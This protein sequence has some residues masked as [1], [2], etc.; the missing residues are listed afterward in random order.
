VKKVPGGRRR[1]AAN[2]LK[3]PG[4]FLQRRGNTRVA[5]GLILLLSIA[6]AAAKVIYF[7]G[8][9]AEVKL[10]DN[11]FEPAR[12]KIN[13]G[14]K[15]VWRAGIAIGRLLTHTP[16]ITYILNPEAAWEASLMPAGLWKPAKLLAFDLIN[17]D[18]GVCMTICTLLTE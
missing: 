15:V 11:G 5:L 12:I 14:D 4:L 18:G 10:G 16:V 9:I 2:F 7:N 3:A 17:Q 8:R 13:L 6:G 1:V